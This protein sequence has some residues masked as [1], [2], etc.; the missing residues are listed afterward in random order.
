LADIGAVLADGFGTGLDEFVKDVS[1]PALTLMRRTGAREPVVEPG[2][3]ARQEVRRVLATVRRPPGSVAVAVGSRG[4]ANLP[5]IVAAVV[6]EMRESGWDPFIVPAMGSH[7][8]GSAPGQVAVLNGLGVTEQAVAAPIR[9]TMA[10][11]E[12][13]TVRGTRVVID[14]YV[15]QAGAVFLINRVKAHTD[16]RGPIESGPAKMLAIGL[17]HVAGAAELHAAGPSG[18]SWG[19]PAVA[20]QLVAK[21]YVLGAVALVENE[22]GQTAIVQGLLPEEIGAEPEAQLLAAA[23]AIMPSLPFDDVDVLVVQRLGK[24]IS[25]EGVDPNV[26]GRFYITGMPE[27]PSPQVRCIVALSLTAASSGN[28]LGIGL[29]D[30]ISARLARAVD[31]TAMYA[32]ALTAGLVDIRRAKL[33]IVLPTDRLAIQAALASCGRRDLSDPRLMWIQDT[34]HLKTVAVSAALAHEASRREDLAVV[35]RGREMRFD[36]DGSLQPLAD[37]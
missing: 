12:V 19:I 27:A 32:N 37:L 5:E 22:I 31:F 11:E 9:A 7:G 14:R 36:A 13:G 3:L 23:K 35:E 34:E 24:D 20:G 29:T 21:G 33:P 8:G 28:A 26:I 16:F 4:I 6:A 1:L 18:L 2:M 10:V 17:G 30:F 25:G 15:A